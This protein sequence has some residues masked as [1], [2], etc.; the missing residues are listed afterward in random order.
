M[1]AISDSS[2]CALLDIP[3]FKLY[4]PGGVCAQH[5]LVLELYNARVLMMD[6]DKQL[7]EGKE[8]EGEDWKGRAVKQEWS[9]RLAV[10]PPADVPPPPRRLG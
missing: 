4:A 1:T 6:G 3:S 2:A 7:W 5:P 9:V 10:D 8:R